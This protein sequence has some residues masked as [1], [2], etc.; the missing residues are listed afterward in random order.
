[1]RTGQGYFITR[2]ELLQTA[3]D[4]PSDAL[5]GV[6]R[7]EVRPYR[8][9]DGQLV[10]IGFGTLACEPRYMVDGT[11]MQEGF[12]LDDVRLD[13]IEL[14][15]IYRGPSEVPTQYRGGT[16]RCGLIAIRI[17]SGGPD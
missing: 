8:G 6:P 3:I 17:R 10:L 13:E 15:E 5:R 12:I 16:N 14:I 7:V 2:E 1:M 11:L 4:R 9:V